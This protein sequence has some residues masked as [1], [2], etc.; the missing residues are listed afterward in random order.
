MAYR[1]RIL[2]RI[3]YFLPVVTIVFFI[4]L[5]IS[6]ERTI[7][8]ISQYKPVVVGADNI[9]AIA[10][11]LDSQRYLLVLSEVDGR[12]VEGYIVIP[13]KRKIGYANFSA[14]AYTPILGRWAMMDRNVL[15]GLKVVEELSADFQNLPK[16]IMI[17]LKGPTEMA[18]NLDQSA[19][20]GYRKRLICRKT[21]FLEH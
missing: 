12:R 17:T 6:Y 3:V 7:V 8:R 5:G 19:E 11:R 21:I 2:Y 20:S 4:C 15:D 13:L 14:S 16:G 10:Y 18:L 9:K 1:K